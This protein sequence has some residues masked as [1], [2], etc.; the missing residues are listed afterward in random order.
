[1]KFK[2]KHVWVGQVSRDIGIRFTTKSSNLVTHKIDPDVDEARNGLA[3][4]LLF[5]Q[6][7]VKIGYVKGVGLSTSDNPQKNLTDDTYFTNGL[8]LVLMLDRRSIPI[9][10]VQ[11]FHWDKPPSNARALD[12]IN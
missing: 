6:G 4:D 5:S 3:E 11:F 9:R 12:L 10:E 1:M 7:L 2:G 8:R